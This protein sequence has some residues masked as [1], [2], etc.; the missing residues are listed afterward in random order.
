MNRRV[1][2][3]RAA[4][5]QR[6]EHRAFRIDPPQ[7][8]EEQRARLAGLAHE[9]TEAM[10]AAELAELTNVTEMS[11]PPTAETKSPLGDPTLVSAATSL[12]RAL[13]KLDS[14]GADL[15]AAGRHAHRYLRGIRGTLAEAGLTIHDH[16]GEPFDPGLIL[17]VLVR[18]DDEK[19]TEETVSETVRPTLFLHDRR[20]QTGQV[21][22]VGPPFT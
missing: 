9:I 13:R 18:E 4:L 6:R 22:V 5:R 17:E 21:V 15:P 1:P 3:I 8:T 7:W 2:M 14:V 19:A 12:W 10:K 20:I 11:V 16:D